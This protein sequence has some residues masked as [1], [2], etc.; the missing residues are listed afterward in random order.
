MTCAAS[1]AD[2]VYLAATTQGQGGIASFALNLT[3]MDRKGPLQRLCDGGQIRDR[4]GEAVQLA[5][6]LRILS[7]QGRS[8]GAFGKIQVDPQILEPAAANAQAPEPAETLPD[9][10]GDF[11]CRLLLVVRFLKPVEADDQ[12]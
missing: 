5:G 1:Q 12:K 9:A 3:R 4:I 10:N 7:R 2:A 6:K 11:R 8:V